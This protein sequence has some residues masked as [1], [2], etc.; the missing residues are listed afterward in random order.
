MW[1]CPEKYKVE[2]E[3]IN[4]KMMS[5]EGFLSDKEAKITLAKFLHA[6]LGFTT[7]L[8]SGIKLAPFQEVTLRGMMNRN[9]SMCVWGRGCGKT[10]IAS[11]FCFFQCMINFNFPS[12]AL[13]ELTKYLEN[14]LPFT[15][16]VRKKQQLH[17]TL[18]NVDKALELGLDV[19]SPICPEIIQNVTIREAKFK[20]ALR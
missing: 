5:I 14:S 19:S 20:R 8:I 2:P 16:K 10:F 4:E 18:F 17:C 9:F 15:S 7:E 13:V 6:N 1:Y 12:K 3:N 11:I